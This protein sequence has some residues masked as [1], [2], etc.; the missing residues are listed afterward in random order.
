MY[1]EKG[2][3]SQLQLRAFCFVARKQ[4]PCYCIDCADSCF[5]PGVALGLFREL[6]ALLFHPFVLQLIVSPKSHN[7]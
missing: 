5:P 2:R 1:T 3:R 4:I 6:S 7:H